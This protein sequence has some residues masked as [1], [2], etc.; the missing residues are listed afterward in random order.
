MPRHNITTT[1]RDIRTLTTIIINMSNLFVNNRQG[2]QGRY[3]KPILFFSFIKHYDYESW[4][5]ATK[6]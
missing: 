4:N 6:S 3:D 5:H 2:L 1:G